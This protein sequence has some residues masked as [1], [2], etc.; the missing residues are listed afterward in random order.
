MGLLVAFE[1]IR[2]SYKSAPGG[3]IATLIGLAYAPGRFLLDFMRIT[4]KDPSGL[5]GDI[6][7][8]GLTPA[9]YAC[10]GLFAICLFLLLRPTRPASEKAAPDKAASKGGSQGGKAARAR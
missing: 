5:H 3:R 4:D 7:Y 1:I 10:I 9:Q 6:R 8:F 2:R